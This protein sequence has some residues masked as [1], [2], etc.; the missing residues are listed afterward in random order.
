MV[1]MLKRICSQVP[2]VCYSP[3]IS[4]ACVV[5]KASSKAGQ[6]WRNKGSREISRT[7]SACDVGC[8]NYVREEQGDRTLLFISRAHCF[9]IKPQANHF[10]AIS[11][12]NTDISKQWNTWCRLNSLT[13]ACFSTFMFCTLFC[14]V[15]ETFHWGWFNICAT[16]HKM[17]KTL[18]KR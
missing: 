3:R 16:K 11:L 15:L 17:R 2:G 8:S 1:F 18:S 10:L 13:V 7:H 4:S 14:G 6:Q 12:L 5:E 9:V